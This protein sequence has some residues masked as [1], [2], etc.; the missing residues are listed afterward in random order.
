MGPISRATAW[1]VGCFFEDLDCRAR[2]LIEK[3]ER[4]QEVQMEKRIVG[5]KQR[6]WIE[7]KKPQVSQEQ[8]ESAPGQNNPV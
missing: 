6:F 2:V 4:R 5:W 3:D 8:E 1:K 7:E